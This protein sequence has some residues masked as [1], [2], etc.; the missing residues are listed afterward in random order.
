MR[1]KRKGTCN[2]DLESAQQ[3]SSLL[4]KECIIYVGKLSIFSDRNS[5]NQCE[6]AINPKD[7]R[8]SHEHHEEIH[9]NIKIYA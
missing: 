9:V 6:V 5:C 1:G 8:S 2:A 7:N 3:V 4:F